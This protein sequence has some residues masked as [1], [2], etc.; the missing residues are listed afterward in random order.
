MADTASDPVVVITVGD[1]DIVHE[2]D[3]LILILEE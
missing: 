3:L 1:N 2:E